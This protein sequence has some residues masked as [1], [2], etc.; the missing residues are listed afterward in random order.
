MTVVAETTQTPASSN[1]A[2][3]SYDPEVENLTIE[4]RSGGSYIYFNVPVAEYRAMQTAPSAGKFF[5]ARIKN[6]YSYEAQ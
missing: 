2:S 3:Y 5:Y 4:F 6:R 1:I